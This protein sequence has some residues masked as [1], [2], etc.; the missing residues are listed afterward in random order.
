M[1]IKD[2]TADQKD[3]VSRY[4]FNCDYAYLEQE[5]KKHL[6]VILSLIDFEIN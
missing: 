1:Y 5:D 6:E 3:I 2:L 4:Y